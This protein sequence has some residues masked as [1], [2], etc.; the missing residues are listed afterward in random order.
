MSHT[1]WPLTARDAQCGFCGSMRQS[2]SLIVEFAAFVA[3]ITSPVAAVSD[4]CVVDAPLNQQLLNV[5]FWQ[6]LNFTW[7]SNLL[8]AM[9]WPLLAEV[10]VVVPETV[11]S[12]LLSTRPVLVAFGMSTPRT[13]ESRFAGGST[14]ERPLDC[15]PVEVL[16]HC[17]ISALPTGYMSS[18]LSPAS[19]QTGSAVAAGA[20]VRTKKMSV[21]A[22]GRA[23]RS[24]PL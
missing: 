17:S 24:T 10:Y 16:S 20:P 1:L 13:R 19:A 6:P 14:V 21:R 9:V 8:F 23:F 22:L 5:M 18:R 15:Q 2:M 4:D 11:V 7:P 3:M 12:I